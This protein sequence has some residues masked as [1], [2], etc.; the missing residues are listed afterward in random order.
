MF[1]SQCFNEVSDKIDHLNH[2][3]NKGTDE[4]KEYCIQ[5][6][7]EVMLQTELAIQKIQNRSDELIKIISKYEETR[8]D[9]F[10]IEKANNSNF[11]KFNELEFCQKTLSEL[12]KNFYTKEIETEIYNNKSF[13]EH[14]NE[15]YRVENTLLDNLI[16]GN[17]L[18]FYQSK[19]VKV[20]KNDQSLLG[21]F[22]LRKKDYHESINLNNFDSFKMADL[23]PDRYV[24][25]FNFPLFKVDSFED[26][27]MAIVY[28]KDSFKIQLSIL[29]Q[30]RLISTSVCCDWKCEALLNFKITNKNFIFLH[31]QDE[32][33]CEQVSIFSTKLQIIR[34]FQ[35]GIPDPIYNYFY[36]RRCNFDYESGYFGYGIPCGKYAPD[37]HSYISIHTIDVNDQFI[38]CLSVNGQITMRDF[39]FTILRTIQIKQKE[40]NKKTYSKM[41]YKFN[42]F[43]CI[44]SSNIDI[45]DESTGVILKT[46]DIQVKS[47]AFDWQ[48]NILVMSTQCPELYIYNSDGL[49]VKR[50]KIDKCPFKQRMNTNDFW[51]DSNGQFFF[52][53]NNSLTLYTELKKNALVYK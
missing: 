32:K 43:Y 11:K 47:I 19:F 27:K 28:F 13:I 45:I 1:A 34:Q 36:N 30:N 2:R 41:V 5:L 52:L 44:S 39:E 25:Y 29:D 15:R 4:L 42:K 49:F 3:F 8:V 50:I 51:I 40:N 23:F 7:T 35:I 12:S 31:T 37:G 22:K 26:G 14:I 17:K 33:N 18:M 53:D 16:Y 6:K 24:T 46:I 20:S 9:N 10:E 48:R 38:Y 21:N